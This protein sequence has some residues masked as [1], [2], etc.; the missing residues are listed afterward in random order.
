MIGEGI[1]KIYAEDRAQRLNKKLIIRR[2]TNGVVVNGTLRF[3]IKAG[4]NIL[5]LEDEFK[6]SYDC[7]ECKGAGK[8]RATCLKCEGTGEL[9]KGRGTA[10]FPLTDTCGKCDGKGYEDRDCKVCNGKGCTVEIP[11]NQQ[12]KPTSGTIVSVGP[13]AK[14]YKVGDRVCYTTYTGH[15]LPFSENDRIRVMHE[16]EAMCFIEDVTPDQ[17]GINEFEFA[18]GDNPYEGLNG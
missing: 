10:E 11:K 12:K 17:S 6:S 4:R 18:S 13:K 7:K 9:E 8:I 1:D 14:I 16:R 2:E 5:I 3:E 15:H